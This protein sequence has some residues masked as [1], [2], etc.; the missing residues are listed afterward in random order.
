[1]A[2]AQGRGSPHHHPPPPFVAKRTMRRTNSTIIDGNAI[3][4]GGSTS[5]LSPC[6]T[7]YTF[8]TSSIGTWWRRRPRGRSSTV[9]HLASSSS[10]SLTLAPPAPATQCLVDPIVAFEPTH[11]AL[12]GAA[13]SRGIRSYNEDTFRVI[14]SLEAYAHAL[15][16]HQRQRDVNHPADVDSSQSMRTTLDTVIRDNT[17]DADTTS[18]LAS[19]T[20]TPVES[21]V[22]PSR[23]PRGSK[24]GASSTSTS[25]FYGVYDGHAGRRC[26]SV[27]AQVLPMCVAAADAFHT[28]VGDALLAACLQMDKLFLD[29]A[30]TR[31]YRD[32]CTAITVVVRNDEV[33]I[34]NIGD[35]RAVLCAMDPTSNEVKVTALTTDQK[36]NCAV[37]KSRIE[38]AGGIVLNIRGIPRVNGMLAV[39]R[40][41]G[42]LPLKRYIVAEP[43]VTRYMLQGSDEYIVM[44]TDGLWDVFSNDAVGVFIRTHSHL[45]LNEMATKMAAMAVEL[46][47]TDNVTVVII[48]VR[49]HRGA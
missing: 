3:L 7:A 23:L 47:S 33:T 48:D 35:C 6:Y 10:S 28:N 25:Q 43:D 1:M 5:L 30:A 11:R 26:S 17:M 19:W 44:A 8:V 45:P 27:V 39:A 49:R 15:V 21:C 38:A 9:A 40:A 31:G 29:M 42:D 37:E 14:T 4:R 18:P 41:F 2:A 36:P 34:A 20:L 46:G 12:F 22:G 24:T 16:M 32:G 13:S